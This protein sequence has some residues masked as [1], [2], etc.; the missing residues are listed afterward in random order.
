MCKPKY[1]YF[2]KEKLEFNL[3]YLLGISDNEYRDIFSVFNTF[4]GRMPDELFPIGKIDGGDL[5]CINKT[6]DSIYYWFHEEDDWGM[7]GITKWPTK[8]ASNINEY[9]DNL[10]ASE[11]PTEEELERVKKDGKIKKLI[12]FALKL[13]NDSREKKGLP[14]LTME[15]ALNL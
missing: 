8:I 7:E 10:I 4:E 13:M 11:E 5:L 15:E 3:N 1:T 2:K 9:L 12:P 6:N 14:P